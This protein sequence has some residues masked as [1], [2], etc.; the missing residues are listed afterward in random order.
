M[1]L[2]NVEFLDQIGAAAMDDMMSTGILG[3]HYDRIGHSWKQLG[4]IYARQ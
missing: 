2:T 3:Q 1:A 4:E